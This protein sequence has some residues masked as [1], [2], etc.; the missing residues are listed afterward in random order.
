MNFTFAILC[1]KLKKCLFLRHNKRRE[2]YC[3][4]TAKQ[5]S[6]S[7]KIVKSI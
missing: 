6:I 2:K 4:V 1:E 5:K 7:F 3:V